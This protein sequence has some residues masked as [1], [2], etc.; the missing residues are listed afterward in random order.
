MFYLYHSLVLASGILAT[1]FESCT[2]EPY[3]KTSEATVHS[4]HEVT[5][6]GMAIIAGVVSDSIGSDLRGAI[7]VLYDSTGAV[8]ITASKV[9]P[10]SSYEI[11]NVPPGKYTLTARYIG[12]R[13]GM[14][15]NLTI[16][17]NTLI[18]IDFCLRW[19]GLQ[20][21]P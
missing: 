15:R 19:G 5:L 16:R 8:G 1:T 21:I 10:G 2:S 3:L 11:A 4:V 20:T 6:G 12:Y 13:F 18:V 17:P 14:V 9:K 7:V